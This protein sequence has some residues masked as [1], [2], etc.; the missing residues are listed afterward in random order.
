MAQSTQLQTQPSTITLPGTMPMKPKDSIRASARLG[1]AQPLLT[2]RWCSS[3]STWIVAPHVMHDL[4][5]WLIIW[6]LRTNRTFF[7]SSFAFKQSCGR[8]WVWLS[9]MSVGTGKC[10][11]TTVPLIFSLLTFSSLT[12]WRI[13]VETL[14]LQWLMR[15]RTS[16][17]LH[18]KGSNSNCF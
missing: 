2:H 18:R 3:S 4:N 6:L 11:V 15:G 12:M 5:L 10:P 16:P 14:I 13:I 9:A 17:T 1:M 7:M 8:C